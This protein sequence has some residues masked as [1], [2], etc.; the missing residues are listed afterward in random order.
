V[1]TT[2]PAVGVYNPTA[3]SVTNAG[4][5]VTGSNNAPAMLVSTVA[6]DTLGNAWRSTDVTGNFSYKIYDKLGRLTQEIDALGYVTTHAYSVYGNEMTLTRYATA[7]TGA[8]PTSGKTA[9]ATSGIANATLDRTLSKSYDKRNELLTVAQSIVSNYDTLAG[10][11]SGGGTNYQAAP[12]TQYDHDAFGN[13]VRTRTAV[14][15]GA[16][17]DTYSYYDRRSLKIAEIS[18]L[19]YFTS[20]QYNDGTGDLTQQNEFSTPVS[21]LPIA[22]TATARKLRP[23]PAMIARQFMSMICST[24]CHRDSKS[25]SRRAASAAARSTPIPLAPTPRSMSMT[26]WATRHQSRSTG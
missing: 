12:V 14:A 1:T 13:V 26:Q 15:N 3:D 25:I 6:Y 5:A 22:I 24:G 8:A 11:S 20:Y 9:I 23:A 21:T 4:T 2:Y 16:T 19:G 10:S 17:A 18:P 7:Y